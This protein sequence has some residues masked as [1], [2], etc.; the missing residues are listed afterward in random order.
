[1]EK[2]TITIKKT[3]WKIL[4][5]LELK[6]DFKTHDEAIEFLLKKSRVTTLNLNNTKGDENAED[7]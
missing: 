2:I 3:N 4:K 7:N 1:M 6:K 5:E